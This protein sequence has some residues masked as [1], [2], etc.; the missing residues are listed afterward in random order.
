[1]EW[2]ARIFENSTGLPV[3][4]YVS[5]PSLNY[6]AEIKTGLFRIYQE[7]LTNIARH[8]EAA[9]VEVHLQMEEEVYCTAHNG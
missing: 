8:A 3:K 4:L 7:S 2:H 1:M 6:P 5:D 9:N